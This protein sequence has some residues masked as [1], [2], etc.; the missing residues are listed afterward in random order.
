MKGRNMCY[1]CK[2]PGHYK[3]EC[4]KLKRQGDSSG[5]SKSKGRVYSLD[6]ESVKSNNALIMDVCLLGQSEVLVLFDCGATNSFIAVDCVQRLQ[7]PS[8]PLI[9]PMTVAVATGGKVTSK[10]VCQACPVL[11]GSK[12]YHIDVTSQLCLIEE[13]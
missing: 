5:A 7:L 4:P 2:Q 6:G 9:P 11:V 13:Y 1:Y 10:R 3:H 8:V 12:V